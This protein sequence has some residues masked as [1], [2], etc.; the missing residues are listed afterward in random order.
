M[1]G[2]CLPLPPA[3]EWAGQPK[4][5]WDLREAGG[6]EA[7]GLTLVGGQRRPVA[8]E[9]PRD[10]A[11]GG[12]RTVTQGLDA[13]LSLEFCKT[14]GRARPG[15][16]AFSGA[17]GGACA[18]GRLPA[19]RHHA[20]STDILLRWEL[21]VAAWVQRGSP[22]AGRLLSLP[23]RVNPF[24]QEHGCP[25]DASGPHCHSWGVCPGLTWAHAQPACFPT[26]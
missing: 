7:E 4:G 6:E 19:M 10:A 25:D 17:G 26:P 3:G 11:A 21:E 1:G 8:V 5:C 2:G 9:V 15:Q 14:G 22:W 16:G 23:H 13:S 12:S 24:S 18:L 20:G